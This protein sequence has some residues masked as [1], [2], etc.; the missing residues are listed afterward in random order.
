MVPEHK[1]ALATAAKGV[2]WTRVDQ[3]AVQVRC[4]KVLRIMPWARALRA[5][6]VTPWV[7]HGFSRM[8]VTVSNVRVTGTVDRTATAQ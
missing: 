1:A 8:G 7:V 5:E 4:V 3:R 2:H 6:E